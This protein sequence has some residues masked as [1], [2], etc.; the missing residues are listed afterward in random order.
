MNFFS[1]DCEISHQYPQ[2]QV[3][4]PHERRYVMPRCRWEKA[5]L[6]QEKAFGE[7]CL[8]ARRHCDCCSS[9]REGWGSSHELMTEALG[10]AS[11]LATMHGLSTNFG[12]AEGVCCFDSSRQLRAGREGPC[13][14]PSACRND[15]LYFVCSAHLPTDQKAVC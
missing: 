8:R 10:A 11:C 1:K 14:H 5:V 12:A 7:D 4:C 13:S 6:L 9:S 2:K 15:A 3:V